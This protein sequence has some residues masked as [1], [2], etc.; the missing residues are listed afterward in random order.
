MMSADTL[1]VYEGEFINRGDLEVPLICG[2]TFWAD[3]FSN[4]GQMNCG[5]LE[6]Y[7]PFV[8][9]ADLHCADVNASFMFNSGSMTV[10]GSV[11]VSVD[12]GNDAGASLMVL[13]T[14]LLFQYAEN[15]GF[16]QCGQF[17]N[18]WSMGTAQTQINAGGVLQC[19]SFL[20]QS[21]GFISGPGSI[22]I[23]GHSE[24]HGSIN[25]PI[26]ICDITLDIVAPP[27]LDVN[28]GGFSQPIYHCVGNDCATV[29]VQDLGVEVSD[30]LF[31]V[32]ASGSFTLR[33]T[34]QIAS[35][36]IRDASGRVVRTIGPFNG[37]IVVPRLGLPAGFYTVVLH[38]SGSGLPRS[39][40]LILEDE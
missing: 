13:D 36:E 37:E 35:A 17:V 26:Q 2:V 10:D 40:Q 24:N 34:L 4:F 25:A 18:G 23:S 19:A 29:G 27:Y 33:S 39:L 9:A 16:I 32:P 1:L 21:N 3:Q 28:T 15:S 31:P 12:L 5:W 11:R 6:S 30:A 22:C 20:N 38:T 8:N 7:P 14:L